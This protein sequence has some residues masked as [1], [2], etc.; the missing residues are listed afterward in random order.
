MLVSR[1]CFLKMGCVGVGALA[2]A[3]LVGC[4]A[5]P[6]A[7]GSGMK[8]EQENEMS[9]GSAQ[10][11]SSTA[12]QEETTPS[13]NTAVVYFS[14]TGN[15]EAVAEKIAQAANGE[16]LRIEA[17]EPYTAQDLDYNSDCR[18]NAEQESG[19]AR[20]AL[21][22]PIPDIAGFDTVYLGYPI[23]WGE[24][25]RIVLT[26]LEGVGTARKRFVPFCTSGSSPISGSVDEL[27]AAA[28]EAEWDEGKR[29]VSSAS[30]QEID[31]WVNAT[32]ST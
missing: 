30:Q 29:F 17:A 8:R 1:R 22:S 32:L 20:P 10:Q 3:G 23:W 24:A 4:T 5:E 2:A 11:E 19:S 13:T 7:N 9:S 16:L 28:P 26:F 18:A 12:T 27:H 31:A 25:P 21:A 6:S 14:C 15:T